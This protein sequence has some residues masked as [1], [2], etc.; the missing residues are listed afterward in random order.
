MRSKGGRVR[1]LLFCFLVAW[2]GNLLAEAV[3]LPQLHLERTLDP[4]GVEAYDLKCQEKIRETECALST[5]RNGTVLKT[6][7]I[8]LKMAEEIVADFLK[9]LPKAEP[10]PTSAPLLGWKAKN[11]QR[12]AQGAIGKK[13]V[14]GNSSEP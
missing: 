12:S 7:K 13:E 8:D 14:D 6:V 11:K 10:K 3:E 9:D 5:T 2:A 4:G 1:G